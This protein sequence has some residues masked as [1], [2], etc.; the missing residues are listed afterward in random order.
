M[1]MTA[2]ISNAPTLSRLLLVRHAHTSMAGKFCGHSDPPL[3][4]QGRAE[5]VELNRRLSEESFEFV[6]CSDLLRARETSESIAAARSLIVRQRR[7]LRELAFGEW[8]GLD[9]GE[10]ETRDPA[11]AKR[12]LETYPCLAAP[13]GEAFATFQR[14]IEHAMNA[15]ADDS[16]NGSAVVVTHAG[17]IRT[18]LQNI[19]PSQCGSLNRQVLTYGSCWEIWRQGGDWTF[20]SANRL[21]VSPHQASRQLATASGRES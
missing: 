5:L 16:L 4:V 19:A 1:G 20:A 14:R 10:I 2:F 6:F 21:G 18:F 11:Y 15:I 8:E 7:D 17:V 13:G 12:W 3:S 9:W